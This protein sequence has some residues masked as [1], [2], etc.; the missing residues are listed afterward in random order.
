MSKKGC[1]FV[2]QEGSESVGHV[3]VNL[4]KLLGAHHCD[5]SWDIN[6]MA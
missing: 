4:H 2:C 5:S 1:S 6:V 3:A